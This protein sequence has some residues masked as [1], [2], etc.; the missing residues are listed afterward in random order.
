MDSVSTGLTGREGHP[1]AVIGFAACSARCND[2]SRNVKV[3]GWTPGPPPPPGPLRGWS[4]RF[5]THPLARISVGRCQISLHFNIDCRDK[6]GG[7]IP[8]LPPYI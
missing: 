3:E 8:G 5:H 4:V 7:A 6:N 1:A 2:G